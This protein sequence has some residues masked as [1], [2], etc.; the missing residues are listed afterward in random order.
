MKNIRKKLSKKQLKI[1]TLLL[2][3]ISGIFV[4]ISYING[5]NKL[6]YSSFLYW[7][8]VMGY[9][10][11]GTVYKSLNTN[12]NKKSNNQHLFLATAIIMIVA[13][14]SFELIKVSNDPQSSWALKA[15][16][17]LLSYLSV[18]FMVVSLLIF[19]WV[20]KNNVAKFVPA[21]AIYIVIF[22]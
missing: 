3:S 12:K 6:L 2:F 14:V 1:S 7:F 19:N 4:L 21:V 10:V 9:F 8:F 5:V 20:I 17:Y 22:L 15:S 16:D 13:L 11:Y 18:P